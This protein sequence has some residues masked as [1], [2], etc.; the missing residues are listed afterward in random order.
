[1]AYSEL[2]IKLTADDKAFLQSLKNI[3]AKIAGLSK[4][5]VKIDI[6]SNTTAIPKLQQQLANI[7]PPKL[8]FD[9]IKPL[10]G[11]DKLNAQ[12]EVTKLR[13]EGLFSKPN[14]NLA[15]IKSAE[16]Q[17]G[18][19]KQRID[20][21]SKSKLNIIS[22]GALSGI[23]SAGNGLLSLGKTLTKVTGLA[24]ALAGVLGGLSV[25]LFLKDSLSN[26]IDFEQT[27][28]D[29]KFFI[30]DTKKADTIL[31]KLQKSALKTGFAFTDLVEQTSALTAFGISG[32]DSSD[33][34]LRLGDIAGNSS[35]KLSELVDNLGKIK[36]VG[37]I[38]A[39]DLAQFG[40]RGFDVR[41][42]IAQ[43]NGLTNEQLDLALQNDELVLSYNDITQAIKVATSEGGRFFKRSEVASTTLKG[44]LSNL[45]DSFEQFGLRVVGLD[46]TGNIKEGSIYSV[47]KN[48]GKI[49]T[50]PR[51]T[52]SIDNLGVAL[53]DLFE[54]TI[55][56]FLNLTDNGNAD[57]LV[58]G[59]KNFIDGI[60]SAVNS[61]AIEQFFL[62]LNG[63]L[64]DA[65][66][67]FAET[68]L[69]VRENIVSLLQ[70]LSNLPIFGEGFAKAAS[71]QRT[72]LQSSIKSVQELR[73][74]LDKNNTVIE[75]IPDRIAEGRKGWDLFTTELSNTDLESIAEKFG[76]AI[77]FD[78]L[79]TD[80][81]PNIQIDTSKAID[82]FNAFGS[83][84][85]QDIITPIK[86]DTTGALES[87]NM[88]I[89]NINLGAT[90][91]VSANT[92]LADE[93]ISIL[94]GVIEE[95]ATMPVSGNI[96][97][98]VNTVDQAKSNI[99]NSV[100]IDIFANTS[101]F[102]SNAQNA[103]NSVLRQINVPFQ[104]SEGGLVPQYLATGGVAGGSMFK[105]KG[106][107]TVPAMLTPGE[108][109]INKDSVNTLGHQ[110]MNILNNDA[111]KIK[112][113]MNGLL[114][115]PDR[116]LTS[117]GGSNNSF[118]TND[119]KEVNINVNYNNS[120]ANPH[121]LLY[122]LNSLI[123]SSL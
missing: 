64:I 9:D 11:L 119:N 50:D 88:L 77:S 92:Q 53:S 47:V 115:A 85:S 62:R 30:N 4:S 98:L 68:I 73:S 14:V 116:L 56:A 52:Q 44:I 60:T 87:T 122:N 106:T 31:T 95:G 109:V 42:T 22:T 43:I 114:S 58:N 10:G 117:A 12:L 61:G 18:S 86:A 121:T 70:S 91:P 90:L 57:A 40:L 15:S 36:S 49:L 74:E 82:S 81:A 29:F 59:I 20:D 17:I 78:S 71:E 23:S 110:F 94:S 65:R 89:A 51:V 35:Q 120:T 67:S 33:L 7:K 107:D 69:S 27:T 105:S 103:I 38:T 28:S 113:M 41:S 100:T 21:L 55:G 76:R 39:T 5:K 26:A 108:Y 63:F 13:Y 46:V 3:E 79:I 45:F 102:L 8:K 111:D 24:S 34:V 99:S 66:L 48:I 54:R 1:M 83:I 72:E 2:G 101:S 37:K 75:L 118:I 19:L 97:E 112:I 6:S 123:G 32:D 96:S 80:I 16:N 25:G 104:F 84:A 93:S